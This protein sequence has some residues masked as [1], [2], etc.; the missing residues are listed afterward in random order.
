MTINRR[1]FLKRAYQIGGLAGLYAMGGQ[2]LINEA[3][4]KST[5]ISGHMGVAGGVPG[6]DSYAK[7]L[8]HSNTTDG[9]TTFTDS[10][11]GSSPAHGI[12]ASGGI[13]HEVDQKKFGTTSIDFG[14]TGD[15]DHL[16]IVSH[17][18]FDF[19]DRTVDWTI[20]FWAY[21]N[22]SG[23][24]MYFLKM[25]NSI[26]VDG[27]NFIVNAGSKI[28]F[29]GTEDGG[30]WTLNVTDTD[31]VPLTTWTHIAVCNDSTVVRLYVNGVQK[32]TDTLGANLHMVDYWLR[33]GTHANNAS[34]FDGY[35]DEIRISKGICRYKNG[36]TF[37]P[38]TGAYT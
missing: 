18:D 33:F 11:V 8:I 5:F 17:A 22:S 36:T 7:L 23:T 38:P 28:T 19:R 15:D 29:L 27:I 31:N 16:T 14:G 6:N 37:T 20:D 13:H 4:A 24:L 34:P 9:S 32:A 30:A 25:S 26:A 35:M 1:E 10:A 3:L 12:T 21:L 2:N